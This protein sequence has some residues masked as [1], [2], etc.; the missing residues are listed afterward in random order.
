MFIADLHRVEVQALGIGVTSEQLSRISQLQA[1]SHS[2]YV[3][4]V[5]S[6]NHFF[7]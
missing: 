5:P 6:W 7:Q 2:L 3:P 1:L 4:C